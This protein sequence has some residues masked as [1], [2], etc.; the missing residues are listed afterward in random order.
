MEAPLE[1][2]SSTRRHPAPFEDPG[3]A[4]IEIERLLLVRSRDRRKGGR[5]LVAIPEFARSA[6]RDVA[7]VAEG[8]RD[9]ARKSETE[10]RQSH[11]D[12]RAERLEAP[13][14]VSGEPVLRCEAIV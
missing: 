8:S 1:I 5:E 4:R 13:G 11:H 6:E 10:G 3:H 7:F 9:R 14:E 2:T 12:L